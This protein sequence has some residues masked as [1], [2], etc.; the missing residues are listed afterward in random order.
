[1]HMWKTMVCRSIAL[2]LM[3]AVPLPALAQIRDGVMLPANAARIWPNQP[4]AQTTDRD[5][6]SLKNGAIIGAIVVGAWCLFVCGQGLDNAG[7]LP[8][9]VAAGAGVGALMGAGIDS[10]FSRGHRVTFRWRF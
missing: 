9:A 7:Q 2:M 5:K 6:D 1:M 8:L 3:C 10:G 4:A